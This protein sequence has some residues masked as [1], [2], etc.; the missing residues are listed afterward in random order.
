ML[1]TNDLC[2]CAGLSTLLSVKI[3]PVVITSVLACW[4]CRYY[5]KDAL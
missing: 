1:L 3:S 2:V 4:I 5:I